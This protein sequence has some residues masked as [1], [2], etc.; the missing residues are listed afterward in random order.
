MYTYNAAYASFEEKEKG[1][2]E[3]GKLADL[4][5]LNTSLLNCPSEEILHVKADVTI[6][7]G[8]IVFTNET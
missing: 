2:I 8:E 1:S 7:D 5:I 3:Q 6:L 4:V